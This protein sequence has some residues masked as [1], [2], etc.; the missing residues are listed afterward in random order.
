VLEL[1]VELGLVKR[2][3]SHGGNP[4]HV[5]AV[6]GR[7]AGAGRAPYGVRCSEQPGGQAGLPTER[8]RTCQP[9]ERLGDSLRVTKFRRGLE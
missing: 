4:L 9:G 5:G 6:S 8:A 7:R 3:A 2:L 1:G